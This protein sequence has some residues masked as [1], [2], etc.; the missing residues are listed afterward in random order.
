MFSHLSP[1]VLWALIAFMP[2]AVYGER[3]STDFDIP[4][5]GKP[6]HYTVNFDGPVSKFSAALSRNAEISITAF[7]A[8]STMIGQNTTGRVLDLEGIRSV[9]VEVQLNAKLS[10]V[11]N[12][13][14]LYHGRVWYT[15]TSTLV[16]ATIN[17]Q[18]R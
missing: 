17:D 8:E 7:D 5:D 15:T 2:T 3:V 10:F 13:P 18:Q 1:C 9:S 14:R 6:H 16:T 12:E 4:Q 11:T